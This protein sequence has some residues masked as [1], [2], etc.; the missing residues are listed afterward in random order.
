[1]RRSPTRRPGTAPLRVQFSSAATDPDGDDAA[2]TWATSA[3]ACKAGGES[4]VHTY[5][6]PATYNAKVTVTDP[7][8]LSATAT[9]Q[10][11]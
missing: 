6:Q 4:P 11:S 3:T 10:S 9:V 1:M 5:T 2:V 8:G 7:G